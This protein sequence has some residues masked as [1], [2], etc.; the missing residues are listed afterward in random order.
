MELS[1]EVFWKLGCIILFV[2]LSIFFMN[3]YDVIILEFVF[4]GRG[5]I[6]VSV[7]S[8]YR[9]FGLLNGGDFVFYEF[10]FIVDVFIDFL[11]GFMGK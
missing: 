4:F 8:V 10:D 7:D 5:C 1:L 9:V 6:V 11:Y 3:N 2:G